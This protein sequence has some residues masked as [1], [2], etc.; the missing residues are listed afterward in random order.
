MTAH[1]S[2]RWCFRIKV[3]D[4]FMRQSKSVMYDYILAHPQRHGSCDDVWVYLTRIME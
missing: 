2:H 1:H 4:N 3:D